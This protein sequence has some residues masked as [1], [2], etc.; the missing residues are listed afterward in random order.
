MG[1]GGGR[2]RHQRAAG[3]LGRESAGGSR[4]RSGS[5]KTRRHPIPPEF[6]PSHDVPVA[7][8]GP[9]SWKRS[10]ACGKRHTARVSRFRD[11]ER[12]SG[13]LLAR[14]QRID[15]AAADLRRPNIPLR[16][17]TWALDLRSSC[18]RAE[19]APL[20]KLGRRWGGVHRLPAILP[21]H[22]E[23]GILGS[24]FLFLAERPGDAHQ[25]GAGALAALH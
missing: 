9:V 7:S 22:S 12:V 23:C 1:T 14:R 15:G 8:M 20:A 4:R 16:V 19:R 24:R 13:D 10:S 6:L 2:A 18:R 21:G 11:L 3:L 5:T 25:G 17:A